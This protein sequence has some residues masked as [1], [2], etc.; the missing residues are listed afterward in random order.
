LAVIVMISFSLTLSGLLKD[1]AV[2]VST[3]T[4]TPGQSGWSLTCSIDLPAL[5]GPGVPISGSIP[6]TPIG[7]IGAAAAE[8]R[9]TRRISVS[10]HQ[11]LHKHREHRAQQIRL[12]ARRTPRPWT[13]LSKIGSHALTVLPPVGECSLVHR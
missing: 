9:T 13:S 3:P 5:A 4:N 11:R 12:G 7:P 8:L 2:T 1:H 10:A 6:V